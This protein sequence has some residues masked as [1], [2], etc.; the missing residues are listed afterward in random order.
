MS[1]K[2]SL[3]VLGAFAGLL[4]SN[5]GGEFPLA[6][7]AVRLP[8]TVRP[9]N[10][11]PSSKKT[12]VLKNIKGD[13]YMH[14]DEPATRNDISSVLADSGILNGCLHRNPTLKKRYDN[15]M[16]FQESAL[17]SGEIQ[18]LDLIFFDRTRKAVVGGDKGCGE[19]SLSEKECKAMFGDRTLGGGLFVKDEFKKATG[20]HGCYAR[21]GGFFSSG[22]TKVLFGARV[23]VCK[24]YTCGA[25]CKQRLSRDDKVELLREEYK[26]SQQ[27]KQ[28]RDKVDRE[29]KEN[30]DKM[31]KWNRRL[32]EM[33][34][35]Q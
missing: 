17:E 11:S 14:F 35:R 3:F 7:E 32:E 10:P 18:F 5:S 33:N 29:L 2:K 6:V 8:N 34:R 9:G 19:E 30:T 28:E 25:V 22:E 15:G 24:D 13:T 20:D 21:K 4:P 31:E 23:R 1:A 26:R 16:D 12:L 27:E